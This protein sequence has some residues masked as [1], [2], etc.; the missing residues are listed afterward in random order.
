MVDEAENMEWLCPE[1]YTK[2]YSLYYFRET[3]EIM[4]KS[5]TKEKESIVKEYLF[6]KGG[7]NPIVNQEFT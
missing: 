7:D 4:I 6:Y 1:S 2:S 5:C 3:G